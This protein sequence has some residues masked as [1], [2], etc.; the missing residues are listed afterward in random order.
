MKIVLKNADKNLQYALD[1]LALDIP[2]SD[3]ETIELETKNSKR[4]L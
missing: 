2:L 3:G 4:F 1:D